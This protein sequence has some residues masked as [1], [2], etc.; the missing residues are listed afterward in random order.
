MTTFSKCPNCGARVEDDNKTVAEH[1]RELKAFV[2][3]FY[4]EDINFAED[5]S[6]T[7]EACTGCQGRELATLMAGRGAPFVSA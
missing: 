4:G 1:V 7:F 6:D 5:G 2:K 3:G